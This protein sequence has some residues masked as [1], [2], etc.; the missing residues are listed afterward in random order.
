MGC[1]TI[2]HLG[3]VTSLR[4]IPK[5]AAHPAQPCGQA[6]FAGGVNIRPSLVQAGSCLR[7]FGVSFLLSLTVSPL[8]SPAANSCHHLVLL[9]DSWERDVQ[10]E[11]SQG[12][13]AV[14]SPSLHRS[15]H[16]GGL[17]SVLLLGI[18]CHRKGQWPR[19]STSPLKIHLLPSVK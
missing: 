17:K 5:A 11:G 3:A 9:W 19:D 8:L 2:A 6:S 4:I 10:G 15:H 13:F 12:F 14:I 1:I 7:S 18:K 16:T